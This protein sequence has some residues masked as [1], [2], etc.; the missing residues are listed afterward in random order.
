MPLNIGRPRL[1]DAADPAAVEL[2]RSATVTELSMALI[3]IPSEHGF[4]ARRAFKALAVHC[5]IAPSR[6]SVNDLMPIHPSKCTSTV[7]RVIIDISLIL[8][9]STDWIA[10]QQVR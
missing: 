1:K 9:M 6:C 5:T 10:L 4:Y 2:G 7:F 3:L 8:L